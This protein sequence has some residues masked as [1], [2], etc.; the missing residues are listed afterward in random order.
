MTHLNARRRLSVR[1]LALLA[2][3]GVWASRPADAQT[4]P[5]D[6]KAIILKNL[7]TMDAVDMDISRG[8][9]S[10]ETLIFPVDRR[11]TNLELS[12]I[13]RQVQ[14]NLYGVTWQTCI[15]ANVCSWA[16][17][18]QPAWATKRSASCDQQKSFAVFVVG[19]RVVD[20]RSALAA[21]RCE[22]GTYS[23]VAF[24]RPTP[25]GIRLW[26]REHNARKPAIQ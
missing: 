2:A 18:V 5:P 24:K 15:R 8:G 25:E 1:S 22:S 14:T 7:G 16:E 13:Q 19:K 26:M 6:F 4:A 21:D 10:P 20:S 3:F 23:P 11:V 9:V 12:D 17:V